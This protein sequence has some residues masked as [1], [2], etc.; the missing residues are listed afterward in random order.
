MI[1]KICA[2]QHALA[3]RPNYAMHQTCCSLSCL[4]HNVHGLAL[5]VLG[6]LVRLINL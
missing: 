3:A 2:G 5:S 4:Y 1:R 6:D